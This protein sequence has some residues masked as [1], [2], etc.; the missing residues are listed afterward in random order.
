MKIKSS[1][2]GEVIN[3][4]QVLDSF[5]QKSKKS[6][7]TYYVVKCMSCGQVQKK[8][9]QHI[10][11]GKAKCICHNQRLLHG[12]AT[13]HGKSKSRLYSIRRGMKNRCHNTKHSAYKNY[14]ARGIRVCDEW[15]NNFQAFYEWAMS[16][17]YADN[18]TID[19]IDVNGDYCPENCRWATRKEQA[20]NKRSNTKKAS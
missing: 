16:N 8:L 18:L 6:S 2:I 12:N 9:S 7:H 17:G 10:I 3:G 4:F 20:N 5:S 1:R 11:S 14:G 15:M 13:T 19:R